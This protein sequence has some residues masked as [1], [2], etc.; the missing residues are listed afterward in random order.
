M[1]TQLCHRQ[2]SSAGDSTEADERGGSP[3]PTHVFGR[4]YHASNT[5]YNFIMCLN[6]QEKVL[7]LSI[8]EI[9]VIILD[10]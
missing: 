10:L 6:I 9:M 8:F 2:A 3:V 4:Q 1:E 5:Y 7:P